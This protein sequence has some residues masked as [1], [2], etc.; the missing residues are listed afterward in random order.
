MAAAIVR[1]GQ[2]D[3]EAWDY[4]AQRATEAADSDVPL[5]LSSGDTAA[6]TKAGYSASFLSWATTHGMTPDQ[7][8]AMTDNQIAALLVIGETRDRRAIPVLRTGLL[9]S[10][11]LIQQ[12]AAMALAQLDDAES[13]PLIIQACQRARGFG[14]LVAKALPY[15]TSA[16]AQ[17]AAATYLSKEQIDAIREDITRKGNG[18]G[19]FHP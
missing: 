14:P 12:A 10:N 15:F 19:R 6:G 2:K 13:V 11:P 4:L 16:A 8:V 1:L 5:F 9:S 3:G 7:A 18:M 17:T